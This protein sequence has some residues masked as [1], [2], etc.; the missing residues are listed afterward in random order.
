MRKFSILFLAGLMLLAGCSTAPS[1]SSTQSDTQADRSASSQSLASSAQSSPQDQD[2]TTSQSSLEPGQDI[3]SQLALLS[4]DSSADQVN[5]AFN[6]LIAA[7][8]KAYD[9]SFQIDQ[10]RSSQVPE[11]DE[12]RQFILKTKTADKIVS[13]YLKDTTLF[14]ISRNAPSGI[15]EAYAALV[16]MDPDSTTAVSCSYADGQDYTTDNPTLTL[17]TIL[18]GKEEDTSSLSHEQIFQNLANNEMQ[19]FSAMFG[20]A[21][22]IAPYKNPD[23]YTFNLQEEG[24]GYLFTIKADNLTAYNEVLD[25]QKDRTDL[26]ET[27]NYIADDYQ[28]TKAEIVFH[29]DKEGAIQSNTVDLEETFTL[30]GQS[31]TAKTERS[32]ILH[33]VD[34]DLAMNTLNE[35]FNQ[36]ADGTLKG[37]SQ[38]ILDVPI[39]K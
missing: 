13:C 9:Y 32:D 4:S 26:F 22:P 28:T 37:G 19:L 36:I 6:A 35:L 31:Y 27:G 25:R 14:E 16:K 17:K 15:S 18:P 11:T 21:F 1:V 38:F 33:R 24:D 7:T 20:N 2:S 39:Y 23:F 8:I 10:L 12:N 30:D 5:A 29:L 34:I 3:L